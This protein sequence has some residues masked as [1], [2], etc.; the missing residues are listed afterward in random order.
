[1]TG[2]ILRQ[3]G[4]GKHFRAG[5][6]AEREPA[7]RFCIASNARRS[8]LSLKYMKTFLVVALAALVFVRASAQ[9]VVE[10][11]MEQEQFLPSES[12]PVAV[13]IT[14][15]S[16]QPLHLGAEANWLT[17]S[18]ESS[19]DFVVIKNSEV[20]V[21][22]AF[23]LESSQMATKRV[24]L[25]PYFAMTKRGRYKVIA[26]LRIKD[27]AATVSSVPKYFDV[28]SG[29]QLWAQDFGVPSGTNTAPEVRKYTLEQANYLRS[30]LRLYLQV[31]DAAEARVYKVSALGPMVSFSRPEAQV[32][33]VSQL[34]VLWQAGAQS[35]SYCRVSPNGTVL[36][37]ENYDCFASR[38]R[39]T[40][41]EAGDVLVT[42]GTRRLQASE[43]PAVTPP[44]ELPAPGQ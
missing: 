17:F 32:D 6:A 8:N 36:Q 14:N 31:S 27:W 12:I 22:G 44:N 24:D 43:L 28:I 16:G 20:P 21:L 1:M 15:R 11:T 39:L 41:N 7:S 18:V 19:D 2:E 25:Q 38:P 29:A 13:K 30:Q 4:L 33:R 35:F 10:I 42:G 34:H 37:R 9:V 5:T 40:V 3:G 26:T 23:D